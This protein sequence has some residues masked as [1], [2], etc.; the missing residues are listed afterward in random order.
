MT[1]IRRI[2]TQHIDLYPFTK[3]AVIDTFGKL[4]DVTIPFLVPDTREIVNVPFLI[5]Y[6]RVNGKVHSSLSTRQFAANMAAELSHLAAD[7]DFIASWGHLEIQEFPLL[8]PLLGVIGG[9]NITRP[10]CNIYY[11]RLAQGKARNRL[12]LHLLHNTN[13]TTEMASP[14]E[15]FSFTD[16]NPSGAIRGMVR[17][18]GFDDR[19]TIT[20]PFMKLT[21][22]F[23]KEEIE[24][25]VFETIR[26]TYPFLLNTQMRSF[27]VIDY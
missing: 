6:R 11:K 22:L 13:F 4:P 18:F 15:E 9:D 5:T 3:D 14:D 23:S 17:I 24:R 2:H 19:W 12:N 7:P 26:G 8:R 10:A 25:A 27:V 1:T 20:H 16:P 21:G